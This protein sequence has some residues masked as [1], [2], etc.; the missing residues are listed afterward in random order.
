ML[1]LQTLSRYWQTL[2]HLRPVQ[3]YGRAWFHLARPK[4]DLASAPQTRQFSGL[5][6][7]PAARKAS[8]TGPDS[9]IFLGEP[10]SLRVNGWDDPSKAKLWRYNQHYFDDLNAEDSY[11]RR[12]W[13]RELIS[14]WITSNPPG[15]GSGWEPYPTSQRV[16]NWIKFDLSGGVLDFTARHSLAVQARWLTKRLERHLLGN[17]LLS[18]AKALLFA[19]LYFDGAEA[20]HWRKIAV[21]I[22]QRELS[23]QILPDGGHFELTPMYHALVLEDLADIVNVM[24]AFEIALNQSEKQL[25]AT[26]TDHLPQ[27]LRWL[28]AMTHPD[29]HISFFN[30]ATF[31]VAPENY[32][33]RD[34]VTRLG[35]DKKAEQATGLLHL[36]DSGFARMT[37]NEAVVLCDIGQIGPDYLPGHAHADTLS[38]EL[39]LMG[40]RV[41]VNS[42]ISEYGLSSERFR[43]RGTAAH[44]TVVVAEVDSSEV[45]S[46]FRVGRRARVDAIEIVE[47]SDSLIVGARHDGYTWLPK[48]PYHSRQWTLTDNGLKI[49]DSLDPPTQGEARFHFPPDVSAE[50]NLSASIIDE[51]SKGY[52]RL[53]SGKKIRWWAHGA[54]VRIDTTTWHPRFGESKPC[55]CL[56]LTFTGTCE[57]R[58]VWS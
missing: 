36:S 10:G 30:D 17:H 2:R 32:Q 45:W 11:T 34:Y 4:P 31:G 40:D 50:V 37:R 22:L 3:I 20:N 49:F 38:F 29:D 55:S 7:Q 28:D 19:G 46:G 5:W 24:T 42:G 35:I 39:S 26:C 12:H 18:N 51:F 41:I 21:S 1:W 56:A 16:V 58:L 33:L 52:V 15:I 47:T 27:M 53:V 6:V 13:Q 44:S 25:A 23:E 54:T 8:I 14:R 9:F 57:L 43:Q 48:G